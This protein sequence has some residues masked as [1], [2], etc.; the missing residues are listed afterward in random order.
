MDT[1]SKITRCINAKQYFHPAFSCIFGKIGQVAS[2]NVTMEL[3]KSKCLACLYYGLETSA[4][5][6]SLTN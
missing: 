6:K 1:Y 2:E 3:L 4:I 5:G